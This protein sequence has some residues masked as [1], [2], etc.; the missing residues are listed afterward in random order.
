MH[1]KTMALDLKPTVLALLHR[2]RSVLENAVLHHIQSYE[3]FMDSAVPALF[4]HEQQVF[5]D[6]ET[7]QRAVVRFGRPQYSL[8][9]APTQYSNAMERLTAH[10]ARLKNYTPT[11]GIRVPVTATITND[12]QPDAVP[13]VVS[14]TTSF[15]GVP[16]MIGTKYENPDPEHTCRYDPGGYMITNGSEKVFVCTERVAD[17]LI[18]VF[19]VKQTSAA[20]KKRK[21]RKDCDFVAEMKAL[22][23]ANVLATPKKLEVY[24]TTKSNGAGHPISVSVPCSKGELSVPLATVLRALGA[25]HDRAMCDVIWP[26]PDDA[27]HPSIAGSLLDPETRGVWTKAAAEEAITRALPVGATLGQALGWDLLPNTPDPIHKAYVLGMLVRRLIAVK[28]G[29]RALDDR[30][31]YANKRVMLPGQQ[32][33]SRFRHLFQKEMHE[34]HNRFKTVLKSGKPVTPGQLSNAVNGETL[35]GQ[36]QKAVATGNFGVDQST[37]GSKMGVTQPGSRLSWETFLDQRTKLETP[38]EKT[39]KPVSPRQLHGTSWGFVCPVLSP[40]GPKVGFVKSLALGASLTMASDASVVREFI[41]DTGLVTP[42]T[43]FRKL[44]AVEVFVMVNGSLLGVTSEPADLH[45]YLKTLKFEGSIHPH[46]SVSWHIQDGLI[47]VETDAGRLVR[48]VFR[49]GGLDLVAGWPDVL[50][51]VEYISPME[52]ETALIAPTLGGFD[53]TKHTHAEIHPALLYG[54]MANIIPFSNFNSSVRDTYSS[55]MSKQSTSIWCTNPEDRFEKNSQEPYAPQAP[56]VG[57]LGQA[58]FGGYRMRSGMNVQLAIMTLTGF[59]MEDALIINEGFLKRFGFM[60]FITTTVRES[61]GP[62]TDGR[63][64]K[65]GRP[66]KIKP[67]RLGQFH[68]IGDNGWPRKGAILQPGDVVIGKIV[69][70]NA[71]EPEDA[72]LRYSGAEPVRVADI[73]CDRNKESEEFLKV[74][75]VATRIPIVGDKF[76]STHSQKG[77]CGRIEPESN[78]PTTADGLVPDIITNPHGMPSRMTIGQMFE[79]FAG[80]LAVHHGCFADGTPGES[81]SFDAMLAMAK[82]GGLGPAAETTLYDGRTGRQLEGMAFIGTVTYRR[83]KHMVL[84]KVHARS[85]GKV[86]MNTRQ[87]VEGRSKDGGLRVGEMERDALVGTGAASLVQELLMKLSDPSGLLVCADC[88]N[89]AVL[90]SH[91]KT[92]ACTCG[93]RT[94]FVHTPIPHA[95]KLAMQEMQ[96]LGIKPVLTTEE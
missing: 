25:P 26:W 18:L 32:L 58:A 54:Y 47:M 36:L 4:E 89:Q 21:P 69:F 14:T 27:P 81:L 86:V 91:T 43:E 17:N 42:L 64:E 6:P 1:W 80:R 87:P 88:R 40:E 10:D 7:G 50:R 9:M 63:T 84:D 46:T 16:A 57:T 20:T 85:T 67:D 13:E 59:N 94:K 44:T 56:I 31:S 3:W 90:Y 28:A 92:T 51:A 76:S 82:A 11:V 61:L 37:A 75:L 24:I 15:G 34:F 93:N 79:M 45:D 38:I 96:A 8:P 2:D 60:A 53:P 70:K 39:A 5:T 74:K 33:L 29:T 19:E 66:T 30:D 78:M 48:P 55:T 23:D 12:K 49:A 71:D 35:R 41:A 95:M 72:S 73:L 52:S 62:T 22:T 68:A 65:F 77:V 83:L